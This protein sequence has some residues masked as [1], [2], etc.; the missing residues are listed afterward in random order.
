M[1]SSNLQYRCVKMNH[2][3]IL[4]C[5]LLFS[6]DTSESSNLYSHYLILAALGQSGTHLDKNRYTAQHRDWHTAGEREK[7][8]GI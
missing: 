3:K 2:H 4:N 1:M 5:V 6:M 8:E 7:R